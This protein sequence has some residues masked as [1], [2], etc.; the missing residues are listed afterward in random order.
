MSLYEFSSQRVERASWKERGRQTTGRTEAATLSA[1][2]WTRMMVGI[3]E[4]LN[5]FW[6]KAFSGFFHLCGSERGSDLSCATF[7]P[8]KRRVGAGVLGAVA[9]KDEGAVLFGDETLDLVL[10]L[11]AVCTPCRGP[12]GGMMSTRGESGQS[13]FVRHLGQVACHLR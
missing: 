2:P 8:P 4:M 3:L 6:R 12:S 9:D 10:H 1:P 5:G 7:S 11:G 13:T